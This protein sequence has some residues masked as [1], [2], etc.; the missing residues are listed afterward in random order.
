MPKG[1]PVMKGWNIDGYRPIE[2]IRIGEKPRDRALIFDFRK[3]GWTRRHDGSGFIL[4]TKTDAWFWRERRRWRRIENVHELLQHVDDGDLM[5]VKAAG[6]LFLQRSEFLRE[7][8]GTEERFAHLDKGADDEDAHLHRARAVQDVR[9]L[10]S[11]MLGEGPRTIGF[12]AMPTRTGRKLRPVQR[13]L[14]IV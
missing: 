2:K 3:S 10:Q 6:E 8:T 1:W 13:L 14:L 11:A 4:W 12:A 9:G 5:R 7:V